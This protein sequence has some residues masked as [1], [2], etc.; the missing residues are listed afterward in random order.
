[1]L[2]V[3]AGNGTGPVKEITGALKDLRDKAT[4]EK[5]EFWV[6]LEGKDEP[7]ATDTA[8]LKWLGQAEVWFEVYSASGTTYD[9][10]QDT[11]AS[12]DV[13]A[14]FLERIQERAEDSEDA[15]VLILPADED[16][17]SDAD[18]ALMVFV[19]QA[20]DA[21]VPVYALNGEMA[22]ISLSDETPEEA[23][24]P[25]PTKTA[26]KK[27]AAPT[28]AA[29]KKAAPAKAA[30]K[31]APAVAEDD[32]A[33]SDLDPDDVAEP[34]QELVVYTP[35]ELAKM[36]VAELGALA[37]GQGLDPKGMGKRDLITA[38]QTKTAPVAEPVLVRGT[39]T[40]GDMALLVIHTPG[41]ILTKY[42]SAAEAQAIAA[43]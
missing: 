19:E 41:Q 43:S 20:I 7:T 13:F 16:G 3:V 34:E 8:I 33:A 10:A 36:S 40:N 1:M 30:T 37:K 18:E 15:A 39:V 14:S 12:E 4:K 32:G 11:I 38:I 23:P 25:T 21:D 22:P 24:E 35:E 17:E 29:S 2:Y 26:S 27:A 5:V 42:I 9:G 28:K 31:K 6:I